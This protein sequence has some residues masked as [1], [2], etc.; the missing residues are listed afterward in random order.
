MKPSTDRVL[1]VDDEPA[2]RKMLGVM[3]SQVGIGNQSAASAEAALDV[4]PSGL[5]GAVISDLRMPG[6]SGL[7]LLSEVQRKH[8]DLPFLVAILWYDVRVGGQ[9]MRQGAEYYR[10]S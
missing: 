5:F 7:D 1:I 9:S 4:L 2:V 3:L 6:I 10:C 8:P